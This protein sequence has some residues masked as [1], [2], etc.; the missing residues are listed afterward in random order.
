VKSILVRGLPRYNKYVPKTPEGWL[1]DL[2]ITK[3]DG[4]SV[5]VQE[6]EEGINAVAAPIFDTRG[7]PIASIAIAGPAY[8]LSE[9]KMGAIGPDVVSICKKISEEMY[10]TSEPNPCV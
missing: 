3:R 9:E 6:Y 2:S 10:L 8:R 7:R 5:S 4:F 1:N